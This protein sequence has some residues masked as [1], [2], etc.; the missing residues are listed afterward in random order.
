MVCFVSSCTIQGCPVKF[1]VKNQRKIKAD[2]YG[3]LT[4]IATTLLPRKFILRLSEETFRELQMFLDFYKKL[5][6]GN[7]RVQ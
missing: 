7:D 6:Q 1:Q 4:S 5:S 2:Q 3:P